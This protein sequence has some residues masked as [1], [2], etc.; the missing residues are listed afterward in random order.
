MSLSVTDVETA[1][2]AIQTSGQNVSVEGMSYGAAD[3][4]K[5][6]Q[7]RDKLKGET[8]RANG[9]RPLFRSFDFSSAGY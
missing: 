8:V 2:T 4:D 7:L 1:I 6:I 5:L 9:S 3:I